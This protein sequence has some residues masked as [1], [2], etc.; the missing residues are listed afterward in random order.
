VHIDHL[1]FGGD[2]IGREGGRVWFIPYAAPAEVVVAEAVE[3]K[4]SFV[5]ARLVEVVSPSADRVP[6]RCRHFG[7]CGGCQWQHLDYAAQL[8]EKASILRGALRRVTD[9]EIPPP[10]SSPEPYG[11]R[12]RAE[13][14]VEERGARRALGYRRARS[15]E[16]VEPLECPILATPLEAAVLALRR[17]VEVVPG[18]PRGRYE[19]HLGDEGVALCLFVER[20]GAAKAQG[21]LGWV[22]EDVPR[23]AACAVEEEGGLRVVLREGQVTRAGVAYGPGVFAQGHRELA[24]RLADAVVAWAAPNRR[25]VLELFAGAGHLTLPLARHARRLVAVEASARAAADARR[26]L[27]AAGLSC[28]VRTGA[29]EKVLPELCRSG[30]R[31]DVVVLDPPRRGAPEVLPALADLAP[32]RI[33]YVSCDPMTLARD[34][35]ALG[36]TG[37]QARAV[38]SFDLFPQTFHLEVVCLLERAGSWR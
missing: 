35:T 17:L 7:V 12:V 6:A 32:A 9:V 26:N 22:L 28:E 23:V 10:E 15:H 4:P 38:R 5:R 24:A 21:W 13:L 16:V 20:G 18:A 3:E 30:V 29:A 27:A 14:H 1:S 11:Y 19:L 33:V 34:L 37:Y 36:A 31:F 2:A 8:R 25:S